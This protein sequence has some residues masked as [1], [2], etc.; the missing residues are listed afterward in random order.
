MLTK[1]GR[2]A[3]L[4]VLGLGFLGAAACENEVLSDVEATSCGSFYYVPAPS[5]P[6]VIP[7][8]V[9]VTAGGG[10]NPLRACFY[11][12]KEREAE[13]QAIAWTSLDPSIATVSPATGPETLVRGVRFG[14]T[15][16]RAVITGVPVDAT[17]VVC[18]GGRCP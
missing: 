9:Q 5:S 10:G 14:M 3:V 16:V 4:C 18:E 13:A 6:T 1:L 17:V 12:D 8:R 15:T 7:A 11:R 2:Q